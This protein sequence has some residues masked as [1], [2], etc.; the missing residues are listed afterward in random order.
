MP[1][2][3][4]P[5]LQQQASKAHRLRDAPDPGFTIALPEPDRA[6]ETLYDALVCGR[7]RLALLGPTGFGKSLLMR[8]L[9]NCPPPQCRMYFV[10][11]AP[12]AA[13]ELCTWVTS[14]MMSGSAGGAGTRDR[15]D[16]GEEDFL[17]WVRVEK[18]LG[19]Q[20]VLLIDEAQSLPAG[21]AEQLAR[22]SR[23]ARGALQIV[24]AGLESEALEGVLAAFGNDLQRV[25]LRQPLRGEPLRAFANGLIAH[26]S[27]RIDFNPNWIYEHDE[28]LAAT[29]GVPRVVKNEI[30]K[31]LEQRE[32]ERDER[33]DAE[34]L[35]AAQKVALPA[36][37]K[38]T[39]ST[40]TDPVAVVEDAT[41][42]AEPTRMRLLRVAAVWFAALLCVSITLSLLARDP[43][44]APASAVSVDINATPWATIAVD[45]RAIG[46]TPLAAV[47]LVPGD[48]EFV[49]RFPDGRIVRKA[50]AI[51]GPT[52]LTF[53]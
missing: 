52:H 45:G 44:A 33:V 3:K 5:P 7:S 40:A 24:L 12:L 15:S 11:F 31:R 2:A 17:A 4:P 8:R 18:H 29:G 20:V 35:S 22:W 39:A 28:L 36:A 9:R 6:F 37:T 48:Y 30:R 47:S 51:A 16:L 41:P 23:E 19:R 43:I 10:P 1:Q 21:S 14:W 46:I 25:G 42:P 53:P 27:G 13:G 26:G 49:A 38:A 50:V 34:A 32:Q